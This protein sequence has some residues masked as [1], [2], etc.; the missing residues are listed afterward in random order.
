MKKILLAVII[1]GSA[2]TLSWNPSSNIPEV[3]LYPLLREKCKDI[4]DY[5]KR[6][7]CAVKYLV[8]HMTWT[9]KIQ[10]SKGDQLLRFLESTTNTC[11][12]SASSDL[13][14]ERIPSPA[15]IAKVLRYVNN[16]FL[17]EWC[18]TN[19]CQFTGG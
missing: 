7:D 15:T 2:G 9:G 5:D 6:K 11:Q 1:T 12:L 4:E 10:D 13:A 3:V 18:T 14:K 16:C 17:I 8:L 19:Y